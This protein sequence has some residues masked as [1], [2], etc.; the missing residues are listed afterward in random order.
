MAINSKFQYNDSIEK[1]HSQQPI[2]TGTSVLGLVFDKGVVIAADQLVSYGSLARFRN[3]QRVNCVNDRTI[4]GCGGD[5]ADY[6]YIAKLIEQKVIDESSYEDGQQIGPKALHNWVTRVQ[7]NKRSKFDPLWCSWVIGGIEDDGKP[8]LGLADRL[9]TAYCSP[10]IATG[11]GNYLAIPLMR[12]E[13]EAKS[14]QFTEAEAIELLN[15]CLHTLYYRDARSLN[16]YQLAIVTA[17][18]GSRIEGP[19]NFVGEWEFAKTVRGY[20]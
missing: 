5:Y 6:Q 13:Y 14:G 4:L 3:V 15:K 1:Q 20:E 9:G 12:Q 11:F 19:F 2:A 16:K 8:Y 17:D 7:Y 10:H 18:R